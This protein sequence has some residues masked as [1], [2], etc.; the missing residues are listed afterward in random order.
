M[1]SWIHFAAMSIRKRHHYGSTVRRTI[2]ERANRPIGSA[3]LDF[4]TAQEAAKLAKEMQAMATDVKAQ[5][6]QERSSSGGMS[7]FSKLRDRGGLK[8]KDYW[9][10]A[11]KEVEWAAACR[12]EPRIPNIDYSLVLP[13]RLRE[14]VKRIQNYDYSKSDEDIYIR[15]EMQLERP[16]DYMSAS[17]SEKSE[18][19]EDAPVGMV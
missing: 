19:E 7:G 18:E 5:L 4:T 1:Y 10:A 15:D 12:F 9:N 6:F 13:R 11:I 14:R 8:G 16:E 2:V 17:S 3:K